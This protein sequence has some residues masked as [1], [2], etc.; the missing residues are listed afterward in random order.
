MTESKL[1][2]AYKISGE[3]TNFANFCFFSKFCL[4]KHSKYF[5]PESF[6]TQSFTK[7]SFAKVCPREIVKI[8]SLTKVYP[9]LFF[10]FFVH[11]QSFS[12]LTVLLF[13][14]WQRI[15]NIGS[16]FVG[17]YVKNNML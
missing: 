5:I 2:L 1:L 9:N 3:L 12:H 15:R 4:A 10:S 7:T 13:V 11:A 6:S 17:K 16:N 8:L 14:M